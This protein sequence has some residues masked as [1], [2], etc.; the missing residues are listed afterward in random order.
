MTLPSPS[1]SAIPTSPLPPVPRRLPLLFSSCPHRHATTSTSPLP[2]PPLLDL[3]RSC[4]AYRF[5]YA[6]FGLHRDDS[7]PLLPFGRPFFSSFFSTSLSSPSRLP[8]CCSFCPFYS[9]A[10]FF[11]VPYQDTTTI[12]SHDSQLKEAGRRA[13]GSVARRLHRPGLHARR[14]QSRVHP[15]TSSAY[16]LPGHRTALSSPPCK[17]GSIYG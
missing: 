2:P 1:P 12:D 10:S 17:L 7:H 15:H 5:L 16:T 6:S 11:T 13:G 9:F 3:P 4:I 14:R 8:F